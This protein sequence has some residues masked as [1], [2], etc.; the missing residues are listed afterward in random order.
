MNSEQ[1]IHYLRAKIQIVGTQSEFAKQHGVSSAHIS[2]VL[3]GKRE[4][5]ERLLLEMGMERIL[6]YLPKEKI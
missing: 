6:I 1:F 5:C 2:D 4:P 3:S